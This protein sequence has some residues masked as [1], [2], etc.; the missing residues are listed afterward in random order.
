M[1]AV[2]N[3]VLTARAVDMQ[4]NKNWEIDP[5]AV[6]GM[7]FDKAANEYVVRTFM[8]RVQRVEVVDI[9]HNK[10][11][12]DLPSQGADGW[13]A[14]TVGEH[15]FPYRLRITTEHG[16]AEIED[17]YCL[18]M[19]LGELD[20][21]LLAEGTHRQAWEKLGAHPC[22]F[23]GVAG[24]SF[25]VWAP[26]ASRVSV[27]GDF[28][29]WDGRCHPMR[30]RIEA[31]I[32]E[33]FIPGLAEGLHYKY[34][35]KTNNGDLLPLKSD[36][37]AFACEIPPKTAA[38]VHRLDTFRW[39]DD[40]WMRKRAKNQSRHAPISIYE[41]HLGSWQRGPD[42][43]YLSYHELAEELIPYVRNMG[44]THLQLLPVS[45]HPFDGSWGYQP[46]GLY[47]PTSR[48]GS[49]EDFCYFVN[50]CHRAGL[51]VIIDWVPGHFPTDEHG[52]AQFDG[53]H[54]YEHADPRQGFH[55]DWNTLI[56]NYGRNEVV[57]FLLN[58][59]LFWLKQYH[60]DGLRVD[61]VASMLYLD[62]SRE[63]SEW[64]P[65]EYGGNEN[66][67]A[68]SF[69]KRLN[70]AVYG[71]CPG[72]ITIAEEST[73]W[74]GVSQPTWLG[75]L[76]F[77][78]KWNMGWM[79][80]TLDYMKHEPIHR[81]YH[82]HDMTFGLLYAFSENFILP[83]SHDE[84]VHGKGSMISRM[85]GDAWQQFASLRA[86]FGFMW[87]HPGKKLLFMGSE[88]A[89]GLEWH[90]DRS[91]DWDL[92]E[93]HWHA[94]VQRLIKDLNWLYNEL[95]TL[96]QHDC[97]PQG[98]EWLKA[99]ESSE[100]AYAWM[101]HGQDNPPVIIVSHFTPIVR[102]SYRVGVPALGFYHEKLNTDAE[103][104]GGSNVGNQ[105]GV[106]AEHVPCDGQPY[107]IAIVAAAAGVVGLDGGLVLRRHLVR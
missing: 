23:E 89:H 9:L 55:Q 76:G 80:D 70:E 79:H 75:G 100:S 25:A 67:E 82:H 35:L 54:L 41:V 49:P 21:H 27:V 51:G 83:L 58:N 19:L 6:R 5:F 20:L 1:K 72:A 11:V 91:L 18:P 73:A 94:G 85:P 43:R 102:E 105:G 62:Y 88:F 33:L 104:Y 84:V 71:E 7:H 30:L 34:E 103:Y 50:A 8:P 59:A 64:I 29:Q 95:P 106:P 44:F 14:G 63:E 10:I 87:M 69:L 46:I 81:Q 15:E 42:N 22:E 38:V 4:T 16:V 101:R 40:D 99:N 53:T 26:N 86:Y 47:A 96:H 74:P 56:Y 77:G 37:F 24:V 61:A 60:I 32:W 52:L 97:E 12:A 39:Q 92:L 36:P 68:V 45:E 65:N 3:D 98:F 31:G 93:I 2:G 13:F 78:F 90:H 48:F 107:S 57:N 28:N 17:P 66:L